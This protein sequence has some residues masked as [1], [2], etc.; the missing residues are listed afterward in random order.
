MQQTQ[1]NPY[2]LKNPYNTYKEQNVLTAKPMELILML[3]NGLRKN[4]LL[5]QR[6]MERHNTEGIHNH[7]VKAQ[8]IVNELINSLDMSFSISRDLMSIYE[9]I[10]NQLS[11]INM[12]KAPEGI[13]ALLE[14]IDTLRDAWQQVNVMQ[15]DGTLPLEEEQV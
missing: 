11:A 14:I 7:L 6:D 1:Q 12:A 4:I 2:M 3:Y 9:F 8:S 15:K 13:D 5:A 10:L